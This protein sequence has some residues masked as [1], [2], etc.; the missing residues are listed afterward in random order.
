[1]IEVKNQPFPSDDGCESSK[2]IHTC[3]YNMR[4]SYR[5]VPAVLRLEFIYL[6]I[7]TPWAVHGLA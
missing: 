5:T 7:V 6:V 1:M 2:Y 4:T 3:V